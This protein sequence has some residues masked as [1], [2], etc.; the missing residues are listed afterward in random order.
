MKCPAAL[1][2]A[3]KAPDLKAGVALAADSI[4]SGRAR[5]KL[6]ALIAVSNS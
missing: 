5:A 2:V 3:D 6:D 4:D 1:V